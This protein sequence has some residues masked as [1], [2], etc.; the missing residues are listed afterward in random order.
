MKNSLIL[1]KENLPVVFI[2]ARGGSKRIKNKNMKKLGKYPLLHF[3]IE[4]AKQLGFEVIVST[5][6]PEIAT[7]SEFTIVQKL[8]LKTVLLLKKLLSII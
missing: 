5:D 8:Y 6:S 2:P 1:N 4:N 7:F 3:P